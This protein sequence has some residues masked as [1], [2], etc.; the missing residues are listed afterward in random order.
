M[1]LR[2]V[3]ALK[4]IARSPF[5]HF[6]I[7]FMVPSQ[8]DLGAVLIAVD[9]FSR[10]VFGF[11]ARDVKQSTTQHLL[12]PQ[13]IKFKYATP[14]RQGELNSL[15]ERTIRSLRTLSRCSI[16]DSQLSSRFWQWAVQH[17]ILVK[18]CFTT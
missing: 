3:P 12:H 9:F 18:K 1:S 7:D 11:Y 15:A 10:F 17:A 4:A 6:S 8:E 16:K 2:T 14:F 13:G 5:T